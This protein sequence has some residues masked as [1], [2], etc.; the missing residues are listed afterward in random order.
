MCRRASPAPTSSDARGSSRASRRRST[1]QRAATAARRVRGRR[2]GRRQDAA[3]ARARAARR[4]A[5]RRVLR[6]ECAAFGAGE[7]PYAPIVAALRALVRELDPAAFDELWGGARASSRGSCPSSARRREGRRARSP[8]ATR[9]AGPPVRAAARRCSTGWRRRAPALRDRGPALGRPLDARVPRLPPAQP[10]RR[11]P[12]DRLHLPQRRAAPPPSAAPVPGRARARAACERLELQPFS[13]ASSPARSR[14]SS[15]PP[16]TRA[17]ARLHARCEGNAFFAEELLAAGAT[18]GDRC[19]PAL[20]DVLAC[21]LERCPTTRARC[22]AW[23]RPPAGVGHGCSP[24]SPA[25]PS[26]RW[27]RR[28]ARRSPACPR[29]TTATATPSATRCCEEAAYAD[30]LPGERARCTRRSPRR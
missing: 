14:R 2:V 21:A 23:P 12:A 22:C 26:P 10:A 16:P 6:G 25:C 28:C 24:R 18:G 20:R 15:A 13:P 1:G 4:R 7:L 27:T 9:R 17:V 8:P 29:R 3:A 30:L 11:A 5:R 19:L